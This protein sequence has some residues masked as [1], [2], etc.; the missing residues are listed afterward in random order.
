MSK[1]KHAVNNLYK[2]KGEKY[3]LITKEFVNTICTP[4]ITLFIRLIY[5]HPHS[6]ILMRC[7]LLIHKACIFCV[8]ICNN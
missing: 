2:G 7:Y 8:L 4:Q 1:M 3:N 5:H 6:I